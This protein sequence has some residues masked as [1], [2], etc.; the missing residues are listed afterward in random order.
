MLKRDVDEQQVVLGVSEAVSTIETADTRRV[1]SVTSG[2]GGV[3]KSNIA[4]NLAIALRRMGQRVLL[5][6]GDFGLANVDVLMNISCRHSIYDV[7]EKGRPIHDII[8]RCPGGIDLL[9]ASSGILAMS[10]LP[11]A[12]KAVL[13]GAFDEL[14]F[15]Y[16]VLI[17]D[18]GAG[19]HGDVLW[20]NSLAD[21]VI[22][23]TTPEPTAIT[24]AYAMIKVLYQTHRIKDVKILVNQVRSSTEGLKV[25]NKLSDVTD[26]FLNIGLDYL[27]SVRWDECVS[28]AVKRRQPVLT[29]FPTSPC[30]ENIRDLALSLTRSYGAT[31]APRGVKPFW[32]SLAGN[33]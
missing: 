32:H 7:I 23:V 25:Y 17:I 10:A 24:D 11:T 15:E 16:D 5:L 12:A 2:K 26:K 9:P 31:M 6:D 33:G 27:G 8:V 18:T 29:S 19:I 4:V 3:G 28:E 14:T 21:E 30:A 22:V 1:I 13:L 20:L